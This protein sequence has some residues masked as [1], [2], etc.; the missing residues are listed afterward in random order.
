[1]SR[2]RPFR[3]RRRVRRLEDS[4]HEALESV[5]QL[6]VRY[7]ETIDKLGQAEENY[8]AIFEDAPVGM[9]RLSRSGRPLNLNRRMA[10]I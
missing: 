6:L 10:Q 4:R 1:M 5:H 3:E 8:R 9:F 7:E 2:P